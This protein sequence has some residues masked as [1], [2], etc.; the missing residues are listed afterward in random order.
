MT[1]TRSRFEE[2][3]S[4][5]V[6]VRRGKNAPKGTWIGGLQ[7]FQAIVHLLHTFTDKHVVSLDFDLLVVGSLQSLF[8]KHSFDVGLTY[9]GRPLEMPI[10]CGVMLFH[11]DGH[12]Q[13]VIF[14]QAV[15]VRFKRAYTSSLKAFWKGSQKSLMDVAKRELLQPHLHSAR[16]FVVKS[17]KTRILYLPGS[18]WNTAAFTSIREGNEPC[19]FAGEAMPYMP[20]VLHFKGGRKKQFFF[21]ADQY[22][23]KKIELCDAQTKCPGKLRDS[24]RK[25]LTSSNFS[26]NKLAKTRLA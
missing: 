7:V 5:G 17:K 24:C 6:I 9:V 23:G 21:V 10:N 14:M 22:F 25:I 15:I 20:R 4:K 11:R 3:E 8:E 13:S 2:I 12:R 1:D 26:S 16:T 19:L 18:V